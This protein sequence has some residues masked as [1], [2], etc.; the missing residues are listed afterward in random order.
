[1][2]FE[3]D[4]P[5]SEAG[6]AVRE[7]HEAAGVV[8]RPFIDTRADVQATQ[9]AMDNGDM[10]MVYTRAPL[11]ALI[12]SATDR[13]DGWPEPTLIATPEIPEKRSRPARRRVWL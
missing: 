2:A 5:D 13:R 10:K 1:M 3:I 6:K 12:I 11:R 4:L 7:A 9:V 8:V